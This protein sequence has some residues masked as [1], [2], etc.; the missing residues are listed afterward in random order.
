ME[1]SQSTGTGINVYIQTNIVKDL[2]RSNI[3]ATLIAQLCIQ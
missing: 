3:F 2:E 1:T